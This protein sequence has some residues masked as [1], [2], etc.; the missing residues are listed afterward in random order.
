MGQRWIW[1]VN[2][3]AIYGKESLRTLPAVMVP[4]EARLERGRDA[5]TSAFLNLSMERGAF[6]S[7]VQSVKA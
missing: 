5:C 4:K 3:G 2:M 6:G 7:L 1:E